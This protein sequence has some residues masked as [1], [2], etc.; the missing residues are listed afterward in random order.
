MPSTD[1]EDLPKKGNALYRSPFRG[2]LPGESPRKA[3]EGG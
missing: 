2:L 1:G 3:S